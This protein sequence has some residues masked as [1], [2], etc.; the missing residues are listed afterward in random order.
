MRPK[1]F[2]VIVDMADRELLGIRA[3]GTVGWG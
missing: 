3:T 2:L 1:V